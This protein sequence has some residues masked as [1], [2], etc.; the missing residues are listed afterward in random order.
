MTRNVKMCLSLLLALVLLSLFA[1]AVLAEPEEPVESS[2]ETESTAPSTDVRAVSVTGDTSFVSVYFAGAASPA[3]QYEAKVGDTVTF[4]VE[5][6]DGY[7][8]D[9]VK[10][11]GYLS[12]L[13]DNGVYSFEVTAD[14][15]QYT[16]RVAASPISGVSS[17][18]PTP[19]DEPSSE[20][21]SS[22]SSA[23]EPS[24]DP[25]SEPTEEAEL[26]VTITGA[27]T[28][29]A[30]GQSVSGTGDAAKT[31]SIKLE[32]GVATQVSLTPA[33]GY[34][35]TSLK[36][37]GQTHALQ[38]QLTL[39]ITELTTLELTFEPDTVVPTTYQVLISCA[40]AGGYLSA[41]GY[42]VTS[43]NATTISVNAGG[44]LTISV[45]PDE[46]YEVDAF[47]VGGAAQNLSGGTYVLEN[48]AASTNITVSFKAKTSAIVPVEATDFAWTADA[49]GL[50][51]IDLGTNTYIGRS[52]FDKINTLSDAD[53]NYVVL[54]TQYIRWY[55]PCGGQVTGV[56]EETLH[57][58]VSLNAN[59]S[60]FSTIDA[61]IR[62]QDPD[63][64][65]NYYELSATPEF[66]DGTLAAFN[67]ADLATAYGGNGVDLMVKSGQSLVVAGEGTAGA[68][69]W[70][71]RM[72]F[73]N[74]RY[75]VVRIQVADQYTIEA[76]AGVNG[77]I[78]PSGSNSVAYQS[79]CAFTVTAN[80]GY[81]I[82][83]VYVDSLP[84]AG[85]AGNGSFQYTFT[86]VTGNHTIRAEFIP[87][88]S[89]YSIV[90]NVAVVQGASSEE[91]AGRSHAGLIVALVIIFV[92]VAGAAALFIVKWRQEKF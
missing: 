36:L 77:R 31:G 58:S 60:Y 59:G 89:D 4:R 65:Y 11:F 52:V 84:V 32:K 21:P 70:T 83:A 19:S 14:A 28:V 76:N 49:D 35:L 87:S 71:S 90:N 61:S 43:G 88:G 42:T 63:T 66:P 46:G 44:S 53:G 91:P 6:L 82:S 2:T 40:T 20:E 47:R 68:D 15:D 72:T 69:G 73:Q 30:N 25:S 45:Y 81:I 50:I 67:L 29:S 12:L 56:T 16:V 1:S 10:L 92:A 23:V 18:E 80:S 26:R 79:D 85:A 75:L 9:S 57:L 78:D 38:E 86:G 24:D 74:S 13:D 8:V 39:T 55:I 64:V 37:D 48:I 41:G 62:A 7:R 5:A 3:T 27:G 54:K 34:R 22:E 51:Q 33:Y 17:D